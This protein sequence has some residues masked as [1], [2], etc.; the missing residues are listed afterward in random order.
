MEISREAYPDCSGLL[1]AADIDTAKD[2]SHPYYDEKSAAKE[3]P[4]WY[5]VEVKFIRKL[6]RLI[7]LKELQQYKESELKDMTVVKTGRL[8][9]QPVGEKEWEFILALENQIPEE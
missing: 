2:P 1:F 4:T 6:K 3:E 8:S 5:M 7:P 9:V